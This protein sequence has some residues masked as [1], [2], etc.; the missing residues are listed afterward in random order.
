MTGW[1]GFALPSMR[2]VS[3]GSPSNGDPRFEKLRGLCTIAAGEMP[4]GEAVDFCLAH[5]SRLYTYFKEALAEM[6]KISW[7]AVTLDSSDFR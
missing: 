2:R 6:G 7:V 4:A 1:V 5:K 3:Y